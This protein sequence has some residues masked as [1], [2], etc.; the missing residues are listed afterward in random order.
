[1]RTRDPAETNHIS[2]PLDYI[3]VRHTQRDL[4]KALAGETSR[5]LTFKQT[6]RPGDVNLCAHG[7]CAQSAGVRL[8]L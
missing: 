4:S 5:T 6:S 1:M 2:E 7:S 8:T 3:T